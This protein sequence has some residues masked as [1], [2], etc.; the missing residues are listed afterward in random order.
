M[1]TH[2]VVRHGHALP[3]PDDRLRPLSDEGRE[4]VRRVARHVAALGVRV[5]EVRHSGL[6]RARQT[7]EIVA[8]H[9]GPGVRVAA[10]PGLAPEDDPAEARRALEAA[11]ASVVLV[12][13]LPHV[14]RLLARMLAG[15][16]EGEVVRFEP[17][18]IAAVA[19]TGE[20]WV[21]RW[22]LPPALARAPD[23]IP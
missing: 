12:G 10:V 9:L 1:V 3:G 7:A 15:D 23:R 19:W 4:D 14:A 20:A 17:G 16:P 8:E 21:L 22:V 13:H 11:R 6:L 2:Y 5:G 18:T